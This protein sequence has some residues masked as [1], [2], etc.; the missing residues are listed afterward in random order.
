MSSA[1]AVEVKLGETISYD[2]LEL[3]FYDIEDSRCPLD[4]TCIWEGEVIAKTTIQNQ[5]HDYYEDFRIGTTISTIFPYDV[6]LIDVIPHPTTAQTPNYVAIFDIVNFDYVEKTGAKSSKVSSP[7]KQFK[8]GIPF[9]EIKCNGNLQLTQK[10]DDSPACVKSEHYF[11]LI[12]RGWVSDIIIAVQ[13]RDVFLDPKDATSSYMEKII[14]TLDDFKNT[15]S[16]TSSIDTIFSKFGK[17]HDDI[18]SGIHIYVYEL[19]DFTKIWIGY[20]DHIL[21]VQHVD[22]DDNLIEELFV[23]NE[24]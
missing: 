17:P 7:L 8:N 2:E 11:E 9:S 4:V 23:K 3:S 1:Y 19:N 24:N 5:T 22:S 16:E 6:T 18:G 10:Y 21:Y 12:K 15:L 20:V 14:P 13:S